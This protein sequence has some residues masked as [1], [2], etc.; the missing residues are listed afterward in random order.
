MGPAT[1]R[2][3]RARLR[4]AQGL[5]EEALAEFLAVGDVSTRSAVRSPSILPWRSE[6]AW[7]T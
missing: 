6:A 1:L 4:M 3:A 5:T 2:L 7:P